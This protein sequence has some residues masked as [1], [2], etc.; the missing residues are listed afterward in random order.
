MN[1]RGGSGHVRPVGRRTGGA[2]AP[3]VAGLSR[4]Y[5]DR[6]PGPALLSGF[7]FLLVEA[8]HGATCGGLAG[9]VLGYRRL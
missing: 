3:A 9:G 4:R 1:G 2:G 7:A 8:G 5:A 6:R